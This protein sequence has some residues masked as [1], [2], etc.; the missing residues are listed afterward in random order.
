MEI[1]LRYISEGK[2][3]VSENISWY[4]KFFRITMFSCWFN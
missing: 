2:K 4:V 1:V 3:N